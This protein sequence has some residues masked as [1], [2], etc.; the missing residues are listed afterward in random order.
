MVFSGMLRPVAL[1]STDVSEVLSASIIRVTRISELGTTLA[2]TSNGRTLRPLLVTASVV[3]SSP[4]LVT[5]MKERQVPPKRRFI[6][7]PLGVTSQ[8]TPFFNTNS[9]IGHSMADNQC[10][11]SVD[12]LFFDVVVNRNEDNINMS[13]CI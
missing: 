11:F 9:V 3:P 1:V 12:V 5:L 6:Q 10:V 8:K 7:E 2:V 4:I 13:D